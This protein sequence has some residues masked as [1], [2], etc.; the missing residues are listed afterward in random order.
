[1]TQRAIGD[2][3]QDILDAVD[4]AIQFIEGMTFGEFEGDFSVMLCW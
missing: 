4:A 1:M 3:V 2:Y